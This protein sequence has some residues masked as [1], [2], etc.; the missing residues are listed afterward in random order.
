MDLEKMTALQLAEKI[1]QHQIGV[2]D[3]VK[4]VFDQI[5]KKEGKVH[6][7]LDTY[8]K[9][10]YARAKQVE[11]GIADGTYTGPLAGVPIA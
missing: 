5:E 10:A 2:L 8:K 3:G 11:K 6:A 7:Y 1:K 4:T 9:E